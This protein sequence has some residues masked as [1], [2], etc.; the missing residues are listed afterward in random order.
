VS[1]DELKL[2]VNGVV[3]TAHV[4]KGARL[5]D[6]LRLLGYLGTKEG[7]G[8][9]ECGACTVLLGGKP[10]N[11]CLVFAR[12]VEG[13]A[14]RTVEGMGDGHPGGLHP[15]QRAL[16]DA[17]GVQCGFCTPGMVVSGCELLD[18]RGALDAN[19]ALDEAAAREA[20]SGNLCRCT[21]Y[22]KILEAVR[23][24]ATQQA[25]AATTATATAAAATTAAVAAES[26]S[27]GERR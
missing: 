12:Q 4:E 23:S 15:F 26:A 21:G 19:G 6:A 5:L 14:V 13:K 9:G 1:Q 10:V 7:C 25:A 11:S 8:E 2:E 24:V 16:I 17:G 3:R 22:S 20:L 27:S 18:R